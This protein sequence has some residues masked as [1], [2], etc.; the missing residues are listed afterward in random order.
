MR[1]DA[2]RRGTYRGCII[3]GIRTSFHPKLLC[4]VPEKYHGLD[5]KSQIAYPKRGRR[6]WEILEIFP[7]TPCCLFELVDTFGAWHCGPLYV[8]I[9]WTPFWKLI[10]LPVQTFSSVSNNSEIEYSHTYLF[11][12]TLAGLSHLEWLTIYARPSTT[13]P[14]YDHL[15][16]VPGITELISTAPPSLRR[17]SLDLYLFWDPG[18][19]FWSFFVPLAARCSSLS[20]TVSVSLL[21]R[22]G[23]HNVSSALA[24]C[25]GLKPYVEKGVFVVIPRVE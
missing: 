17:L 5:T 3:P 19:V 16:P 7:A 14:E 13:G 2:I 1:R 4:N 18:T 25:A 15:S 23:P 10:I 8:L 9:R 21:I 6:C 24:H 12:F 20:I 11:P 22:Q